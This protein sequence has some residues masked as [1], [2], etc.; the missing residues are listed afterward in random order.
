MAF[1]REWNDHGRLRKGLRVTQPK[2]SQRPAYFLQLPFRWAIPFTLMSGVLHWLLSQSFF[3]VR[4]DAYDVNGNLKLDASKSTVGYSS[5]SSLAF[6]AVLLGMVVVVF[7]AQF[8]EVGI[9]APPAEH[10]SLVISAACHPPPN[11][12]NPQL[13]LVQWGVVRRRF[14][15]DARHCSFTSKEVRRPK[16]GVVYT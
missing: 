14:E 6:V 7:G 9:C 13:G 2:G 3:F 16:E 15:G 5:V 12:I 4:I 8:Q 10:C 1:I 11:D